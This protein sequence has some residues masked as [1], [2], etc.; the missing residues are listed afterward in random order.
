[1]DDYTLAR[2]R[3]NLKRIWNLAVGEIGKLELETNEDKTSV[4]TLQHGTDLL[5]YRISTAI[6]VER[7]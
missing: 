5:G 6:K 3:E 4:A 2:A 7:D 1:M